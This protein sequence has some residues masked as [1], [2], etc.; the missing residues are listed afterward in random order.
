MFTSVTFLSFGGGGCF[1][2]V[3]LFVFLFAVTLFRLLGL[4]LKC[5]QILRYFD[6]AMYLNDQ[7]EE[8]VEGL[9][10]RL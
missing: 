3:C 6:V 8:L 9:A 4:C 2:F 7:N 1:F 10:Q 5:P